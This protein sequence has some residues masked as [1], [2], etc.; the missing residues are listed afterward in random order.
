MHQQP[1]A[2][3]RNQQVYQKQQS[4]LLLHHGCHERLE[5]WGVTTS[6]TY[7]SDILSGDAIQQKIE[8]SQYDAV[9]GRARLLVN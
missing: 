7:P 9:I 5:R 8:A 1:Y 2:F 3:G 6:E 4:S